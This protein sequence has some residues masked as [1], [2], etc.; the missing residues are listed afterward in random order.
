MFSIFNGA[1]DIIS[2]LIGAFKTQ[3]LNYYYHVLLLNDVFEL[4]LLSSSQA[5]SVIKL[6]RL[7]W[8][9]THNHDF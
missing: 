5:C 3:M 1:P 6:E 9:H 4:V 7:A 2:I 8:I